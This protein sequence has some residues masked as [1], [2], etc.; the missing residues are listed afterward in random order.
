MR[1]IF[2][3]LLQ[4]YHDN[5]IILKKKVTDQLHTC[6]L[7]A[8]I[9]FI[10][11]IYESNFTTGMYDMNILTSPVF[12]V[13]IPAYN[14]ENTIQKSVESLLTQTWSDFEAIII[15]DGSSD[16]TRGILQALEAS[17]TRIRVIYKDKNEGLSAGRNSGIQAARGS[18]IGFLDSDDW[19]EPDLLET[20]YHRGRLNEDC[21]DLIAFG[22]FHDTMDEERTR[23]IVSRQ[24]RMPE[25]FCSS[26]TEII[27]AAVLCD[28]NKL[29]AYTCT[30]FYRRKLILEH[31]LSFPAQT[32]IED[33]IFNCQYWEFIE[34]L[35]ILDY[36]GYHYIKASSEA[37]TQKFLPDYFQIIELR[38]QTIRNLAV[39]NH[40]F[41][42]DIQAQL[43]NIHIKHLIAGMVRDCS[44]RSG[45]SRK[46][47]MERIR[48]VLNAPSSLEVRRS[49]HGR[50]RQERLCNFIFR[51][52]LPL[53]NFL[54]ASLLHQM[55]THSN[56][57]DKL[58]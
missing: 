45:Y 49:A 29:F 16:H 53:L 32:L 35:V 14:A 9:I 24:V 19:I 55:Q 28:T 23:T 30:K 12:S 48:S 21:P 15:E 50:T 40:V 7:Y 51:S 22:Y 3:G 44:P 58:K 57:F 18:Y 2:F 8:K 43:A 5:I 33:F 26:R 1:H 20:V 11:N 54:F 31:Q 25:Q 46:K 56:V 52:K 41:D 47:R 39:Q 17:D 10:Y 38:Y 42:K 6:I 34:K 27:K 4:Q 36:A 37:L 13:I